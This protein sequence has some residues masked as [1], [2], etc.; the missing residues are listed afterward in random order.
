M[1]LNGSVLLGVINSSAMKRHMGTIASASRLKRLKKGRSSNLTYVNGLVSSFMSLVLNTSISTSNQLVRS[2][3]IQLQSGPLNR[4][5]FLLIAAKRNKS[6]RVSIVTLSIRILTMLFG[7]L[8]F[9][10]IIR[11]P[12][13]TSL[14]RKNRKHILSS[15]LRRI[16]AITLAVLNNMNRAYIGHKLRIKRLSF[17]TLSR[18][19]TKSIK[20]MEITRSKRNRFNA[21]HA[22]RAHRASSL[23]NVRISIHVIC[24]R[25]LHIRQ[26]VRNP[27]LSAR[28]FLTQNVKKIIQMRII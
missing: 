13:L 21:A 26:V 3:S 1:F 14:N 27:V 5:R 19:L 16:R 11:G 4:R 15:I 18:R 23:T 6:V 2:R 9:G 10:I 8:T 7:F 28:M 25:T 24:S 22:R 17:L 20:A 12:T